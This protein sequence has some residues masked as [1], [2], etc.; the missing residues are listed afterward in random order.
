MVR[1]SSAVF[2]AIKSA[3]FFDTVTDYLAPAMTT[4]WCQGL[5]R[6]FERIERVSIVADGYCER[7][8]VI[9]SANFAFA[10]HAPRIKETV[11]MGPTT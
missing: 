6:T 9:V 7:F 10:H 1:L 8:V 11:G 2:T 3:I 4:F 5:D